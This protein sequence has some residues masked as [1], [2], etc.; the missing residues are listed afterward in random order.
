MGKDYTLEE[1]IK[2][3]DRLIEQGRND[4]KINAIYRNIIKQKYAK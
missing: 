4:E 1:I 2:K 3:M